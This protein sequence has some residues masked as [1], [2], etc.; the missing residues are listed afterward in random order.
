MCGEAN[1]S[2]SQRDEIRFASRTGASAWW[3]D[4]L[5][6]LSKKAKNNKSARNLTE[7]SISPEIGYDRGLL[8]PSIPW[9]LRHSAVIDGDFPT[10]D[11][12]HAPEARINDKKISRRRRRFHRESSDERRAV[13]Y[14][15]SI[16]RVR[17]RDEKKK[18]QKVSLSPS[19]KRGSKERCLT[20]ASYF[21]CFMCPR[22]LLGSFVYL[23]SKESEE[24]PEKKT[25]KTNSCF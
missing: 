10:S 23:I 16:A 18:Q 8:I 9:K 17:V 24:R 12:M 7:N 20:F 14:S 1:F 3:F 13:H 11:T 22:L 2:R 6:W 21:T 5:Q 25:R 19:Q 4:G 15:T